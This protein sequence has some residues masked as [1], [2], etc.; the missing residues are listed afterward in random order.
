MEISLPFR[1]FRHRR[2]SEKPYSHFAPPTWFPCL[3]IYPSPLF[4]NIVIHFKL[5]RLCM[6]LTFLQILSTFS[7]MWIRDIRSVGES[8]HLSPQRGKLKY[9]SGGG[10]G[11]GYGDKEITWLSYTRSHLS[12]NSWLFLFSSVQQF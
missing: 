6:L 9:W 5:V 3:F 1:P 11:W 7:S 4:N 2:P 8:K 12:R 10:E